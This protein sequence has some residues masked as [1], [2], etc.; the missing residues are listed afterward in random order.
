MKNPKLLFILFTL[1]LLTSCLPET[2]GEGFACVTGIN[3]N[4]INDSDIPE[5]I[6]NAIYRAPSGYRNID[7]RSKK[8]LIIPVAFRDEVYNPL[9]STEY[10]R[11]KYFSI[12]TGSVRDYF[13]ENSWGQFDIKE[14]HISDLVRIDKLR[15]TQTYTN[16]ESDTTKDSLLTRDILQAAWDQDKVNWFD[17]QSSQK[18]INTSDVQIV[19]LFFTENIVGAQRYSKVYLNTTGEFTDFTIANDFIFHDVRP[20]N[21]SEAARPFDYIFNT[22]NHELAHAFFG[23]PD[24]YAEGR[25]SW[26]RTGEYDLMADNCDQVHFTSVD[27]M[28]LGWFRPK[29]INQNTPRECYAFNA[30]QESPAAL[31]VY[32]EPFRGD[33]W[34]IENRNAPSSSYGFDDGIPKSGLCIWYCEEGERLYTLINGEDP[35]RRPSEYNYSGD[36]PSKD[37]AFAASSEIDTINNFLFTEDGGV[38]L[39]RAVSQSGE[40]MY[41]QL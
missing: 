33:Y 16:H 24:R 15:N 29:I 19:F 8:L 34:L 20:G 30:I 31:I 1:I 5:D 14:A 9:V 40:T 7:T 41:G 28:H 21:H 26:G 39:I 27:K 6:K 13:R 4:T 11:E 23:L 35:E 25:C 36:Y 2:P 22:I 10:I 18:N 12:G 32:N 37:A 3:V 38:R 17:F